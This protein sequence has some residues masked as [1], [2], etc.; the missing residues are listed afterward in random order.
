M[1]ALKIFES[2]R[3]RP[4]LI[5]PKFVMV[6]CSDRSY[7][8]AYKIWSSLAL[9]VAEIIGV[10]KEIDLKCVSIKLNAW[11][12]TGLLWEWLRDYLSALN[13]PMRFDW[14]FLIIVTFWQKIHS[15]LQSADK[16][17]QEMRAVAEKPQDAVVNSIR[18]EIYSGIAR[19]SLR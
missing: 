11:D 12:M 13:R 10:L 19:S 18:I 3:V 5:F 9:P 2:P 14:F 1:V 16:N 17:Q 6:F 7:E 15:S 4:R 8:C